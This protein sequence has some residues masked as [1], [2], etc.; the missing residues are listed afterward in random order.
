M[1]SNYNQIELIPV[2]ESNFVRY[3][4]ESG[5]QISDVTVPG[6]SGDWKAFCNPSVYN[7]DGQLKLILR[8]VNFIMHCSRYVDQN[9]S[10]WGPLE[11]I[12]PTAHDKQLKTTNYLV[13]IYDNLDMKS[14]THIEDPEHEPQWEFEGDEDMRL[15]RWNGQLYGLTIVR[16]DNPDGVAR[17]VLVTLSEDG[18]QLKRL[19]IASPDN[20]YAEKN[21]IPIIN[22]PFHFVRWS[23]PLEIVKV[24]PD[25][26]DLE[27]V[28]TR[29]AFDTGHD[30][31]LRGSSQVIKIRDK[32]VALVHGCMLWKTELDRK[33]ARYY[34][35][36]VVWDDTWKFEQISPLFSF[37]DTL[38]EFSNGMCVKDGD[39]YISFSVCDNTAYVLKV[40]VDKL[41]E[42]ISGDYH[43][44]PSQDID[45]DDVFRYPS[46][47]AEY[48]YALKCYDNRKLASAYTHFQKAID[49]CLTEDNPVIEYE[50]LFYQA[51]ILAD[52]GENDRAER[53]AWYK[54]LYKDV[55]RLEAYV[56]L[57]A[58]YFYRGDHQMAYLYIDRAYQ[59]TD[60][61][62]NI[63][64]YTP[65]QVEEMYLRYSLY[66]APHRLITEVVTNTERLNYIK[67]NVDNKPERIL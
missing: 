60:L 23:N 37:T 11:Y 62:S 14:Y 54:C 57:A 44:Q 49:Y 47:L 59:L 41:F 28:V 24:D 42:F 43:I 46:Q 32:Y 38:V 50:S 16:D 12:N 2:Q 19:K 6:L 58:F 64:Y 20:S 66:S 1:K 17:Q 29:P 61:T 67:D 22:L 5:G 39:A 27:T 7:D 33:Y 51:R 26:G 8:T 9:W 65:M 40:P 48:R 45:F 30:M 53:Y 63:I 34:H 52:I 15:V 10:S 13:D 36:F 35:Q 31:Q 55:M 25:T 21:W 3:C 18:R 56:A 4:L